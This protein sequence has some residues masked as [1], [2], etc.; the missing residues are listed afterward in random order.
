MKIRICINIRSL[1]INIGHDV[2]FSLL[3]KLYCKLFMKDLGCIIYL[4]L[5]YVYYTYVTNN[6]YSLSYT[7]MRIVFVWKIA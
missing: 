2:W 6:H 5:L 1:I 7:Y 3:G 4:L